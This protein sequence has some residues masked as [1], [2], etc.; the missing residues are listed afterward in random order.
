M[1]IVKARCVGCGIDMGM[2][3]ISGGF[4][5]TCPCGAQVFEFDGSVS[6]PMSLEM[7]LDSQKYGI[8]MEEFYRKDIP[9]IEYYVGW[10]E[11]TDK[12]KEDF[13]KSLRL[14]G[15]IPTSECDDKGCIAG[16]EKRKE[17]LKEIIK[18]GSWDMDDLRL[19][20][21]F[22]QSMEVVRQLKKELKI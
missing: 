3:D 12:V 6:H 4:C 14:A 1:T 15:S 2:I 7:Y 13:I 8:A 16:R 18:D 19:A 10:S 11:Y 5:Y 22:H 21:H 17:Q 9:H 20:S